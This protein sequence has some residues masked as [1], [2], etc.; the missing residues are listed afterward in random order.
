MESL[1]MSSTARDVFE[2]TCA[3]LLSARVL[4]WHEIDFAREEEIIA[5]FEVRHPQGLRSRQKFYSGVLSK[6]FI[7]KGSIDEAVL[8]LEIREQMDRGAAATFIGKGD[9]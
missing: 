6:H 1:R 5:D 2:I 7:G 4:D 3:H 9:T 8:P